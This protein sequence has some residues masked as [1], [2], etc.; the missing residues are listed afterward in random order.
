MGGDDA[1]LKNEAPP[2][3]LPVQVNHKSGKKRPAVLEADFVHD[4]LSRIAEETKKRRENRRVQ[5][6]TKARQPLQ[7]RQ[8]IVNVETDMRMNTVKKMDEWEAKWAARER[9]ERPIM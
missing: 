1:T 5:R 3:K 9:K 7:V 4:L 8:P 2:E 6:M